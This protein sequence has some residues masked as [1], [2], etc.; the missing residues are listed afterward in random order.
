MKLILI[1]ALISLSNLSI[2]QSV[3][4]EIDSESD[5][6]F[7]G[8]DLPEETVE[9]ISASGRILILSNGTQ[10]FGKGDFITMV[11]GNK[12]V[13]RA[14][15][16]KTVDGSAGI[17]IL[18]VYD[19]SIFRSTRPGMKYK[20]I[21]GDDS[22]FSNKKRSTPNP[23]SVAEVTE[24]DK[25]LINEEENLFD[26]TTLLNDDLDLEEETSRV[27]RTD[28]LFFLSG[29]RLT[30]VDTDGAAQSYLLGGFSYGFQFQDNIWA[31]FSLQRNDIS[32][33]PVV[34][35][36]ISLT[37]YTAKIMYTFKGPAFTY[38]LPYVGYQSVR[39]GSFET[40]GTT[41][42]EQSVQEASVARL[43][44]NEII[45]GVTILKRLVP[46]WFAR[47]DVGTDLLA[48]G[49]GLEF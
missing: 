45:I 22:F 2:A 47:V 37:S 6:Y 20:I 41:D 27:I 8:E 26:E 16:A 11:L 7:Q 38:I 32:D 24:D 33:F 9:K 44:Q 34:G 48:L 18:K 29:S 36:S 28:H 4:D 31:E 39:A 13:T 42:D 21:R 43:Q 14:L 1:L 3:V 15:V 40:T 19:D 17:K 30:S 5:Q 46:G 10:S 25:T 49:F 12:K 35:T 23:T